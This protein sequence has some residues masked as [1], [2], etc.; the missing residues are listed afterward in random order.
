LEAAEQQFQML[1]VLFTAGKSNEIQKMLGDP[2]EKI[3][4]PKPNKPSR[5]H[6]QHIYKS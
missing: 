5:S 3:A 2:E 6:N 1:K 4:L